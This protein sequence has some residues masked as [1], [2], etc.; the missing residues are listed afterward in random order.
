MNKAGS[1]MPMDDAIRALRLDQTRRDLVRD[2]YLGPDALESASRFA[3]SGEFLAVCEL[4]GNRIRGGKVLDLGAGIGIFSWAFSQ[5]GAT[6][7][8]ALEPD[9]S[10]E[11]GRGALSLVADGLPIDVLGGV[12]E[13]IPLKNE[14]LD[15]VYTR[16]VLHHTSNLPLVLKECERV[17]TRGGVLL[18]T[19]EHVVDDQGQLSTFLENHPIHAL[20][21]GE[22][23]FSLDEYVNAIEGAGLN[24]SHVIG[25]WD[26][27]I[28]AYPAVRSNAELEL[29]PCR[30][31]V[32][33]FGQAGAVLDR[34][35]GVRRIVWSRLK[36]PVPG[37][38]Y[39]FLAAKP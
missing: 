12:G 23:A 7:V 10:R 21:G 27:V 33:R 32:E 16:Q 5:H 14:C 13:R 18:V 3:A 36:R 38:M 2:A 19:R 39:S 35:P 24:I 25:P 15:L 30:L 17:L 20:V 31:L 4:V 37:R 34:L 28:N 8:F 6:R 9:S 11:V 1:K 22:N 29:V 26:S